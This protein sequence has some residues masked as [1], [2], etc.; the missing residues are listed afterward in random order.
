MRS[1]AFVFARPF[2]FARA[3]VFASVVS[4]LFSFHAAGQ[5]IT[6]VVAQ[7]QQHMKAMAAAV[8]TMAGM[9]KSPETYAPAGFKD[10]AETIRRHSAMSL[11]ADFS[12]V[13]AAKGSDASEL[14]AAERERFAQLSDDLERYAIAVASAASDSPG[15]MPQD[16]RMREGE[17]VSGGP[18][19]KRPRNAANEAPISA[20]HA[21]HTMLGTCTSCHARYRL[22]E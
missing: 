7:R 14:I 13:T 10:A 18:F 16:M 19:A 8:R 1:R 20:E 2:V 12:A 11:Q 17:T 9:F 6:D 3:L 15:P 5:S 21:F 4:A 22:K